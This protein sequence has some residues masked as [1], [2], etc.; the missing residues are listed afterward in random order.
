MNINIVNR[1]TK[2]NQQSDKTNFKKRGNERKKEI[3]IERKKEILYV[4]IQF[5]H[6]FQMFTY[7]IQSIQMK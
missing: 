2:T 7:L 4:N 3:K 1:Y 5:I 6:I